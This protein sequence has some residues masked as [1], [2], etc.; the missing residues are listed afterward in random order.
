MA[1]A[2]IAFYQQMGRAGR[3]GRDALCVLVGTGTVI[4]QGAVV[5]DNSIASE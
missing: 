2:Y 4:N 1:E 5:A 3:A